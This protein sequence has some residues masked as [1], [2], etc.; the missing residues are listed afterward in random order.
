MAVSPT[1][2]AFACN[3]SRVPLIVVVRWLRPW[4]AVCLLG[5]ASACSGTIDG[6]GDTNARGL[7]PNGGGANAS[8][9]AGNGGAGGNATGGNGAMQG[10]DGDGDAVGPLAPA[11]AALRRLTR[12]QYL[13]TVRALFGDDIALSV[14]LEADPANNGS[15]AIG[16]ALSTLSPVATEKFENA[17]YEL[18]AQ[19]I[20]PERR[21][22]LGSCAPAGVIARTCTNEFVASFGRRAFRRPLSTEEVERYAVL[23]E[24]AAE[25]LGDFWSGI[26]FAIAGFLQ[27]PRFLFRTELGEPDPSDPSRMRYDAYDMASRLSF[28]FWNTAPDDALLDAAEAGEL[29]E[30]ASLLARVEAMAADSRTRAALRT[31][32]E[33]RLSLEDLDTMSKDATLFPSAGPELA[34]AMREDILRTIEAVTLDGNADYRDLFDTRIVF[35]SGALASVYGVSSSDASEPTTLPADSPRVGLMGKPGLLAMNA[36]SVNTSPTRRGK[37]VRERIMCSDIPPPPPDVITQLPEPDP[38]APTMRDRLREHATN[39]ACAGCHTLMDPIGLAFEHFDAIGAYRP[40]D[41]GHTIDASGELSGTAFDDARALMSILREREEVMSCVV[42]Q[43]YRYATAH[44]ETGGEAV[45]I[46]ALDASFAS[47]GYDLAALL[48]SIATSDG[49]RYAEAAP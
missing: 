39:A 26:E 40:D 35:A 37:F 31:F 5:V 14:E 12:E 22:K 11:P 1:V 21:G 33:E 48:V 4:G 19:A 16:T 44:V 47:S 30:P 38:N 25:P 36:H 41:D 8:P 42:R 9:T 2:P 45:V 27:S 13:S 20:S 28:L 15:I 49:F 29:T 6:F 43:L 7:D 17:A 23:A 46:E 24:T 34:D 32:H 3:A 10:G 18:A